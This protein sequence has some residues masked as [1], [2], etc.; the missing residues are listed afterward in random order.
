MTKMW[1]MYDYTI[2]SPEETDGRTLVRAIADREAAQA[3]ARTLARRYT[4]D[5]KTFENAL[6]W[7]QAALGL[8][9]NGKNEARMIL[10]YATGLGT[11]EL[12][13]RSKELMREDDF[14]EYEK[15]IYARIGT[16]VPRQS[17]GTHPSPR[18]RSAG[19]GSA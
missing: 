4:K 5:I 13:T 14:A 15:R 16:A 7:G 10:S 18:H 3:K 1:T 2:V 9:E 6:A 8:I 12:I 17:F 19:D 11:T